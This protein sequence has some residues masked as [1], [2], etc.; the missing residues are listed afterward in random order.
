MSYV[1]GGAEAFIKAPA[2]ISGIAGA[3]R[4]TSVSNSQLYFPIGSHEIRLKNTIRIQGTGYPNGAGANNISA[5]IT[6]AYG[7]VLVGMLDGAANSALMCSRIY[8]AA[9]YPF[10]R[11]YIAVEQLTVRMP[12]NTSTM[13]PVFLVSTLMLILVIIGFIPRHSLSQQ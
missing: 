6:T 8:D 4:D 9:Q 11:A 13:H 7:T 2:G 1:E 10:N 12:P 3:L 5:N